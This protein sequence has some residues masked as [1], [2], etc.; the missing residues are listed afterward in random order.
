MQNCIQSCLTKCLRIVSGGVH[1]NVH[2]HVARPFLFVTSEAAQSDGT[3]PLLYKVDVHK[4]QM[5]TLYHCAYTTVYIGVR[6]RG[7]HKVLHQGG[8]RAKLFCSTTRIGRV[9]KKTRFAKDAHT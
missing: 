2:A 4:R 9:Q 7:V 1:I 8:G 5:K 3:M 6:F